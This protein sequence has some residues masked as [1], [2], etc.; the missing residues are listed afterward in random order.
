MTLQRYWFWIGWIG[1]TFIA[2]A[3]AHS[4]KM[5]LVEC[6]LFGGGSAMVWM[7]VWYRNQETK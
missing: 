5:E 3:L 6:L 7:S 2:C 1:Q 4:F